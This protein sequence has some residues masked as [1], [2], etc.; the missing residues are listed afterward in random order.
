LQTNGT[1]HIYQNKIGTDKTG[2]IGLP[3][4]GAGI[5]LA[6]ATS[7]RIGDKDNYNIIAFNKGDG[8]LLESGS[9]NA[10]LANRI[11]QNGGLGIHITGGANGG[12]AAPTIVSSS[13]KNG[14]LTIS[15]AVSGQ[16]GQFAEL[17]VFANPLADPSGAGE[18]TEYVGRQMLTLDSSGQFSLSI[19]IKELAGNR[20]VSLTVTVP[21][22]GTSAFSIDIQV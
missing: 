9:D 20:V 12:L 15:G 19:P 5:H 21:G 18:G 4:G 13:I 10:F 16:A 22:L 2:K 6:A 3:N 17:E 8:I 7:C 1:A 11:F 14:V